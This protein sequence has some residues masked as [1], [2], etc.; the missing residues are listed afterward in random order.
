MHWSFPST[1][2]HSLSQRVSASSMECAAKVYRNKNK[3]KTVVNT[4]GGQ[5]MAKSKLSVDQGFLVWTLLVRMIALSCFAC[6]TALHRL[7]LEAGSNPVLGSSMY[8]TWGTNRK[9]QK[10]MHVSLGPVQFSENQRL[11]RFPADLIS[12]NDSRSILGETNKV[13][14]KCE[15]L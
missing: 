11:E 9:C 4:V 6:F 12:W 5:T 13:L 3:K 1:M 15:I 2:I 8:T 14:C 7:F 10:S